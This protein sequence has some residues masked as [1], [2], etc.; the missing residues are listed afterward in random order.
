MA[1]LG[2]QRGTVDSGS[3][4]CLLRAIAHCEAAMR[5]RSHVVQW[6]CMGAFTACA[7]PRALLIPACGAIR[8]DCSSSMNTL[9]HQTV[10]VKRHRKGPCAG[11]E[12]KCGHS[13]T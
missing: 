9:P 10:G 3:M 7:L 1:A 6:L 4:R 13:A 12:K 11:L 2:V 8:D 5:E